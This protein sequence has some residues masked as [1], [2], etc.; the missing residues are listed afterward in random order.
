MSIHLP[1]FQIK[2]EYI[3]T[4]ANNSYGTFINTS[5]LYPKGI[6]ASS[7]KRAWDLGYTGKGINVAVLDTGI[8][9][10]HPDLKN[11]IL[12]AINLTGE[13]IKESHGTH[14]AGTIAANG[15]L[16]GGAP[17]CK[18]IDIKV[19]ATNGGTV[20]NIVKGII[21]A[22]SNGANVINMSL[23]GS[24]FNKIDIQKLTNAINVAWES[25]A[26]CIAASG[27][28][29]TSICTP[30]PYEYPAAIDKSE[31]IAACDVNDSLK[32][33]TLAYFSNEND[34]VDLAAC[35]LNVISSI[36][37][38]KY[39]IYSGTSMATPHVSAM[40]AILAQYIKQTQPNLKGSNFSL[41]LSNLLKSHVIK[42]DNCK[43]INSKDILSNNQSESIKN[44]SF[45]LGFLKYDP[46][47]D[48]IIPQG[49]KY[50]YGNMFIGY[51][52]K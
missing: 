19:I 39:G 27:N 25:G 12:R 33:T 18:I 24:G 51:Q 31:S 45:G 6:L 42:V 15:W 47:K 35:G 23:G 40:A 52:S 30:D 10:T 38:Q 41:T 9:G 28:D 3:R 26:I 49:S 37:G 5:K 32:V 16:V 7:F 13:S 17:D 34:K 29:G 20:D 4:L 2:A 1:E 21:L 11:K 43:L 46:N 50:Y 44:I 14:V 22:I 48:L 36:I 8:D